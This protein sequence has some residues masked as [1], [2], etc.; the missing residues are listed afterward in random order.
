[1]LAQARRRE[2]RDGMERQFRESMAAPE[3]ELEDYDWCMSHAC[4]PARMSPVP[5]ALS[6]LLHSLA[7]SREVSFPCQAWRQGK[8][9][10]RSQQKHTL[11]Q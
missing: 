2:V 8:W 5:V 11:K 9:S 3:W 1:M 7:H 6:D 10:S 4:T